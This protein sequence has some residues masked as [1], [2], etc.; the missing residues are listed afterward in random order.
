MPTMTTGRISAAAVLCAARQLLGT[1]WMAH[2]ARDGSLRGTL[3]SHG[4][5][6][7]TLDGVAGRSVFATALLPDGS[8]VSY[9]GTAAGE[10]ARAYSAAL[11]DM[12]SGTLAPLHDAQCGVRR[13][14]SA[15][16]DVLRHRERQTAWHHGAAHTN[17]LLRSGGRARASIRKPVTR[18]QHADVAA[19]VTFVDPSIEEAEAVLRAIDTANTN[20]RQYARVHGDLARR[21]KAAAPGLRPVTDEQSEGALFTTT[22]TVDDLVTVELTPGPGAWVASVTVQ[23]S[24]RSVLAAVHAA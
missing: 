19:V 1:G 6:I 21:L 7:V 9:A 15:L 22:L 16:N 3:Q 4:G 5:H 13:T 11:S 8:R 23:G 2:P 12:V 14:V 17:W 18:A 24:V 10:T 20:L